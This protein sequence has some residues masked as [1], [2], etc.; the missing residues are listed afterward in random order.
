MDDKIEQRMCVKSCM[1][2][3]K[4]TS[5]TLEMLHEAFGEHFLSRT[6]VFEWPF[7]FQGWSSVS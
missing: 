5:E 4:S 2:L 6:A 7:T 1:K 3:S